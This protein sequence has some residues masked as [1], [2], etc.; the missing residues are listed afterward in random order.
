MGYNPSNI[1]AF[2]QYLEER[3]GDIKTLNRKWRSH[4]ASF[5]AVT[6]PDDKYIHPPK[7]A[8]GL[9]YEFERW[10]RVNLARFVAKVRTFL[11][12]GAPRVPIM[13]DPSSFLANMNG[14][15]AYK[16]A[17]RGYSKLSP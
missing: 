15:I 7:A 17:Y 6:P 14:Y 13:A 10:Q 12:E 3:Y 2:Q 1:K 5:A 4:Y 9:A 16:E 11:R 8:S